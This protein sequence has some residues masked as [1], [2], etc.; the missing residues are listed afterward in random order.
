MAA[1][2]YV[3]LLVS[4]VFALALTHPVTRVGELILV[5]ERVRFSGLQA[6]MALNAVSTVYSDW[7]AIWNARGMKA[8]D[9]LT[10]TVL[11]IFAMANYFVCMAS[12]PRVVSEEP[13]DLEAFYWQFRRLYWGLML[14]MVAVSIVTN[15]TLLR[16]QQRLFLDAIV[17]T[18]PFLVP[19]ALALAVQAR[20][21]QWLANL[22]QLAL[23]I[24]WLIFFSGELS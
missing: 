16:S 23:T 12:A 4:F 1:F 6:M 13:I 2:D 22:A 9:I 15:V 14:A 24:G 7:L 11:F 18:L 17:A 19:P 3:V 8:W 21:A 10:V 20:W 5:H